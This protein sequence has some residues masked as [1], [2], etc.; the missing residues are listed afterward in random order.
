ARG[1]IFEIHQA[2]ES[3]SELS[4]SLANDRTLG[5]SLPA[6]PAGVAAPAT[7]VPGYE[8]LERLGHGGMGVVYKARQKSLGRTVALKMILAGSHAR[9]EELMR[10]RRE[11]ETVARRAHPNIVQIHEV[12][13]PDGRPYFSLECVGG[14]SREKNLA[15]APQRA[16]EAA[17]LVE[18][19]ARVVH[20]AH[21]Q[22][23]I[24]RDLKPANILLAPNPR[25]ESRHSP[26]IATARTE[27]LHPG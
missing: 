9:A 3:G 12:G 23:I 14:G 6:C 16:H 8:I 26:Q 17:Q 18:T 24:H 7:E 22:G 10:F 2:I 13:A 5:S 27:K 20:Y 25:S 21:G 1:P 19:L 11:A 15:G 4:P